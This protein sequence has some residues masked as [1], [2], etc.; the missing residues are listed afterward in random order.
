MN[1]SMTYIQDHHGLENT[2]PN[3]RT[4]KDGVYGEPLVKATHNATGQKLQVFVLVSIMS[5]LFNYAASVNH[6]MFETDQA[7]AD[8]VIPIVYVCADELQKVTEKILHGDKAD[9]EINKARTRWEHRYQETVEAEAGKGIVPNHEVVYWEKFTSHSDYASIRKFVDIILTSE[10]P[11]EAALKKVF[12]DVSDEILTELLKDIRAINI[13][14]YIRINAEMFAS[15]NAKQLKRKQK[16]DEVA[17]KEQESVLIRREFAKRTGSD[18]GHE[19]RLQ[20]GGEVSEDEVFKLINPEPQDK[21]VER[22]TYKYLA[23]EFAVFLL[24]SYLSG[25]QQ[26]GPI[27]GSASALD[28]VVTPVLSYPISASSSAKTTFSAF[29]KVEQL[30]QKYAEQ[31]SLPVIAQ[32][33]T[34]VDSLVPVSARPH[35]SSASHVAEEGELVSKTP[36]PINNNGSNESRLPTHVNVTPDRTMRVPVDRSLTNAQ[37]AGMFPLVGVEAEQKKQVDKIVDK[38]VAKMFSLVEA[39]SKMSG[40]KTKELYQNGITCDIT[41]TKATPE[42]EEEQDT[43]LS[44]E[45]QFQIIREMIVEVVKSALVDDLGD[46]TTVIYNGYKYK[47]EAKPTETPSND[48]QKAAPSSSSSIGNSNSR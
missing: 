28:Q 47:L 46:K 35:N 2:I 15:K 26:I 34:I 1:S 20:Q 11:T 6:M 27:L 40:T 37:A 33:L 5:S 12:P 8:A 18:L 3:F 38:I 9:K 41:I 44:V 45:E 21:I 39:H 42:E 32:S 16:S 24:L 36:S 17:A 31:L 23:E 13:A 43:R 29:D 19:S 7:Y 30:Y 25:A 4:F 10:L 48:G 14:P 22:A